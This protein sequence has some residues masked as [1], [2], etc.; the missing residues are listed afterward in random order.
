MTKRDS[1]SATNWL[2]E[3]GLKAASRTMPGSQSIIYK[4]TANILNRRSLCYN[5][6]G[7]KEMFLQIALN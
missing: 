1:L 5:Y 6:K 3:F 7:T 2:A 4:R